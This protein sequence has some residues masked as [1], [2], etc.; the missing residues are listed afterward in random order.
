MQTLKVSEK[1]LKRAAE[2]LN[3]SGIVVIPTE[4]VYGVVARLEDVKAV[5]KIFE[6]KQRPFD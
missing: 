4:T 1:S 6:T 3:S 2:A 5:K